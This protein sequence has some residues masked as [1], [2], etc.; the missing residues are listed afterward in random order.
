MPGAHVVGMPLRVLPPRQRWS[1]AAFAWSAGLHLFGFGLLAW[2]TRGDHQLP[3]ATVLLTTRAYALHYL[4]L[5]GA[6]VR[7]RAEPR[8][9]IEAKS[10]PQPARLPVRWAEPVTHGRLEVTPPATFPFPATRS[11]PAPSPVEVREL[12]PGVVAG[13]GSVVA[14]GGSG[15]AAKPDLLGTLGFRVPAP[16]EVGQPER[17]LD[18]IAELKGGAGSACPEF[19]PPIAF[20]RRGLAVTVAFVVDTHGIVDRTTL[21]VIESPGRPQTEHRFQSHI[22]VVGAKVRPDR[23]HIDPA[24]YDSVVSHE[25]TSHVADLAFRPAL[26]EG[27]TVRSTVL[28]SCQTSQA[29]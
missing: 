15:P 6:P 5:S 1:R 7:R 4:A 10:E 11:E 29:D 19:R 25:V 13:V 3:S 22:Y 2:I 24:A 12:D 26:K 21:R 16:G 23:G 17:G 14:T 28:I 20:A 8:P 9:R 27:R 18:R